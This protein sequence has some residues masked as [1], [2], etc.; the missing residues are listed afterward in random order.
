MYSYFS[1]NIRISSDHY[2]SVVGV[3]RRRRR[4]AAGNG[5]PLPSYAN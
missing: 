1:F 3:G 5:D 4:N 2:H